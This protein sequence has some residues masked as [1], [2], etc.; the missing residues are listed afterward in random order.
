MDEEG[1]R[2]EMKP[3]K[4]R[5]S[6]IT[7]ASHTICVSKVTDKYV[8]IASMNASFVFNPVGHSWKQILVMKEK[9]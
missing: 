6:F 5:L 4:Q 8:F 2:D 9:N 3:S 7:L 1:A